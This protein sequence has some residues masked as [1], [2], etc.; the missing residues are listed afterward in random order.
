V[1]AQNIPA[2]TYQ[3][4]IVVSS[5]GRTVATSRTASLTV[6]APSSGAESLAHLLWSW[7]GDITKLAIIWW[8][9]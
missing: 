5:S 2:G 4:R 9:A 8:F 6:Q 1:T 3:F 7:L